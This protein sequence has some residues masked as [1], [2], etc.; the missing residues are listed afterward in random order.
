M[1]MRY[2]EPVRSNQDEHGSGPRRKANLSPPGLQFSKKGEGFL[3]TRQ[4]ERL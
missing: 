3:L 2:G 1:D 4:V